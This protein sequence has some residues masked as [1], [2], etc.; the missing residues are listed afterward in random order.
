MNQLNLRQGA[1][2][3]P[4]DMIGGLPLPSDEAAQR[5]GSAATNKIKTKHKIF[6]RRCNRIVVQRVPVHLNNA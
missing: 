3:I 1:I 2:A 5:L 6:T 4:T